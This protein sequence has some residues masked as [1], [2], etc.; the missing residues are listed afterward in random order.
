M[1]KFI[2]RFTRSW[3]AF[4]NK[5]PTP[6]FNLYSS[7]SRPDRS[8]LRFGNAKS[9]LASVYNQISVD[10]SSVDIKHV[11]LDDEDRF[12]EVINDSL[13]RALTKEANID[14]TGRELIKDAVLSMFDEG[15]IAI[16]PIDTD[17]NP[18]ITDSYKIYTLRVGKI[19]EWFPNEILVEVYNDH[20]GQREQIRVEK[21]IA[22]IIENPFYMIM[23]EPNSTAQRLLR[24][25]SQIDKLNSDTVLNKMDLI[26]QLPYGVKTPAKR[27][28]ANKRRDDIEAQLTNSKYGVAYIDSTERVIQ[29]NRPIEN[30]LW[31]QAKEL[32]TQLFNQLGF[33]ESIFDGTADEKTLLNYNNRTI[34]PILTTITDNMERKW[35]S[36]T[37]QSQG[38]AIR[39][40]DNPFKLV[41]VS[42]LAEIADKFT[43][44]EIMTSNE[45]RSVIG[46]KPSDDPK[47][48]MLINSN[49]NHVEGVNRLS[50]TGFSDPE[51]QTTDSDLIRN[52]SDVYNQLFG[53]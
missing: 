18:N 48:D 4:F 35:I 28:L 42:Q 16:V 12:S 49:L 29:L 53:K 41:P 45:I 9:V 44:N 19:L 6:S 8:Y 7:S 25:L 46:I 52:S 36:K 33:S 32:R 50:N 2:E 51:E 20:T 14:Q 30:N 3:N 21:R 40:Y 31:E 5:D 47:A 11:R 27:E 38:Q 22:A 10:V 39:F 34:E 15:V 1:P 17:V 24:T 23:N 26:I 43:R 37:A 13:N